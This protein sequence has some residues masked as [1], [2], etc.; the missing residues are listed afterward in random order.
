MARV[1]LQTNNRLAG[2]RREGDRGQIINRK[3]KMHADAGE[4]VSVHCRRCQSVAREN[5]LRWAP[6]ALEQTIDHV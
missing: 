5:T 1:L 6:T 3:N 4:C 2:W